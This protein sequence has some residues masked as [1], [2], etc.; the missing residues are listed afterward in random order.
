M[1]N[2]ISEGPENHFL[3]PSLSKKERE[4]LTQ[5]FSD[6]G[7]KNHYLLSS[8]GTTGGDWKGYLI[9][10]QSLF[11]NAMAVNEHLGLTSNDRWG[12]SLPEYHIGGLSIYFRAMILNHIPVQLRPWSPNEV[13]DK[14]QNSEVTIISL[15]PTQVYDL[16]INK[17]WAPK[18]LRF[19][20]VGGDFLGRELAKRFVALG[21]PL[22]R[23]FGM[24]EVSSQLC[25]GT[26][27]NGL[28]IPLP[29]HQLKIDSNQNIMVRSQ[30]FYS[31]EVRKT[32]SW[33]ITPVANFLDSEGF[34]KLADK[35]VIHDGGLKVLGRDDGQIKSSGHLINMI[36][37]KEVLD[38]FNL[39]HN[40]WGMMELQTAHSE[41]EGSILVLNIL[42]HITETQVEAFL[43]LIRP[44]KIHSIKKFQSFQR[45]DLGKFKTRQ[46]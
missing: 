45:T 3:V 31:Y 40:C 15:V 10:K 5:V 6:M 9:S 25:S 12:A 34:L 38:K 36:A 32:H 8:S 19:A 46:S 26:N 4:E 44:I 42:N 14:I 2:L 21:W 11:T 37:L 24:T 1:F 27:K 43:N 39:E 29:V 35:G 41:R 30:S 13:V 18:T 20:L 22:V 7:I 23:T 28:Y 16:V 33:K 17:I